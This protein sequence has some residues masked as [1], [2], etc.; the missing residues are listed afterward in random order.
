M[1]GHVT[2]SILDV[3]RYGAAGGLPHPPVANVARNKD[4]HLDVNTQTGRSN[5]A[6]WKTVVSAI[7]RVCHIGE[8]SFCNFFVVARCQVANFRLFPAHVSSVLD[9]PLSRA[10]TVLRQLDAKL[11]ESGVE[12]E[13]ERI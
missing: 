5:L 13:H 10:Q 1:A 3:L 11:S 9:I 7:V 12:V 2:S 8:T 4:Q 6:M